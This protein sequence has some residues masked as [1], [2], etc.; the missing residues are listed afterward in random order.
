MFDCATRYQVR[1]PKYTATLL[2]MRRLQYL[3]AGTKRYAEAEHL[4]IQAD[5]LEASEMEVRGC[6]SFSLATI[7]TSTGL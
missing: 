1:I 2:E 6:S 4:R 3:H 7:N 5:A